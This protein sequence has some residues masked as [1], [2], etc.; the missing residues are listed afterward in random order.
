MGHFQIHEL[1]NSNVGRSP[2]TIAS[3]LDYFRSWIIPHWSDT[4]L[5]DVKAVKMESWLRSLDLA[6][7]SKAKIRNLLSSLFS[8]CIRHE[9][10]TRANPMASVPQSA[11]RLKE[12][13]VFTLEEMS[14]I[15]ANIPEDAIRVMVIV[16]AATAFK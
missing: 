3:Y 5:E 2:S 12:P 15:I 8:H 11:K 7:A 14:A 16:A 13:E 4:P 10:Y 6:P 1:H 9:L